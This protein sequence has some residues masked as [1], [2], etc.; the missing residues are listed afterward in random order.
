MNIASLLSDQAQKYIL[1]HQNHD[2]VELMLSNTGVTG[3]LLRDLVLQIKARALVKYKIP[4]WFQ[5][6]GLVYGESK[7]L[8]QSSSE[9]TATYKSS[10]VSGTS[11]I[12]LTGGLG[13]DCFFLGKKFETVY[14]IEQDNSLCLLAAN[15]FHALGSDHIIV[16]QQKAE[17]FLTSI[18]HPIDWIFVDPDRRRDGRRHYRLEDC[19]P[20]LCTFLSQIW[21]KTNQVMLKLSPMLDIHQ[22]I[23]S[24]D[25]VKEVHAVS[26][27]NECKELVL[28]LENEFSGK[29]QYTG[30]N[31]TSG[32]TVQTI[33]YAKEEEITS[34]SRYSEPLQYLYEPNASLLKLGCFKL[35]CNR[36]DCFKLHPNSHLYTSENVIEGFPGRSF[37][38]EWISNYKPNKIRKL[39][40]GAKANIAVRNF[41]KDIK[42][43][44]KECK[45]MEGG[46]HY[47]FAT[48]GPTGKLLVVSGLSVD[49]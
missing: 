47:L 45:I 8:E 29:V 37:K 6:N 4:G 13:V 30:I 7:S 12:D 34:Y 42:A 15:N 23:N 5:T 44:R 40:P 32:S 20:N 31:F 48:T 38:I 14:Y 21:T 19:Q 36:Y 27:K 25:H 11:M 10:L 17:K 3:V 46:D 39:L 26:I 1:D 18:S 22:A 28:I 2:P 41:I 24:L 35:L 16:I 33:T 49:N 9:I 43:I